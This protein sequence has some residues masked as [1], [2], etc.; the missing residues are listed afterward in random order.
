MT[1]KL[2]LLAIIFGLA[3]SLGLVLACGDDDDDDDTFLDDDTLD[4]DDDNDVVEDLTCEEAYEYLY[5]DCGY[6]LED[7][8]GVIDVDF[9]ITWCEDGEDLFA[10]E[11]YDC[12]N[13]NQGDCDAIVDC[14]EDLLG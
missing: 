8:D 12:I 10:F 7:D 9:L 1:N 6:V 4:D 5:D 13:D 14:I 2:L 11:I 3:L